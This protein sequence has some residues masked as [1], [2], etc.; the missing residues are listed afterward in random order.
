MKLDRM[1][2]SISQ[3]YRFGDTSDENTGVALIC[4]YT[5]RPVDIC[6]FCLPRFLPAWLSISPA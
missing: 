5:L 3:V 2:G 6:N 1:I 4:E